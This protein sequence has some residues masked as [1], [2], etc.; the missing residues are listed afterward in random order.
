MING[1]KVFILTINKKQ[2]TPQLD[3]AEFFY[4]K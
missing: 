2:K 4:F 3:S 1:G